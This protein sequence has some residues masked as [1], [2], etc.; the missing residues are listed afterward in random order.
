LVV[1]PTSA[2]S[3][4]ALRSFSMSF[5]RFLFHF[6]RSVHLGQLLVC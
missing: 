4:D 3:P 5:L 6:L 1:V 2:C